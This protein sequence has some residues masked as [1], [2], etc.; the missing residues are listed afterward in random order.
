VLRVK[1]LALNFLDPEPSW[2]A[3]VYTGKAD[4]STE[5]STGSFGVDGFYRKSPA[6]ADGIS[7]ARGRWLDERRFAMER[8]ILGRGQTESYTFTFD[9][10]KVTIKFENT[11]GFKAELQGTASE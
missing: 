2:V 3:T 8:R 7:A 9:G 1:A 6:P 11:D 10:D 5:R 4:R